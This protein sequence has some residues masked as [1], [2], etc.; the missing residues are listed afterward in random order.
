M[1]H[2]VSV[3]DAHS[4]FACPGCQVINL[5]LGIENG[6]PQD[7]MAVVAERLTNQGVIGK[8]ECAA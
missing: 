7:A 4:F 5:S 2:D 8:Y 3:T 6:W 1:V